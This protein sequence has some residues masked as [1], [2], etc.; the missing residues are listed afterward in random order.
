MIELEIDDSRIARLSLNRPDVHNAFNAEL[1]AELARVFGEIAEAGDVR[2]LVLTG[3]G[4]S[5]SAGA[6][7]N[8]MRGMARAGEAENR[9]DAAGLA[10][11]LRKLDELPCPTVARVNGAAMGGGGGLVAC[12][13]I[14]VAGANAR[15]A[16]SEVRLGLIPATIAPFVLARIGAGQAR[17]WMLTAERFDALKAREIGLVHEVT[18]PD[19]LDEMIDRITGA[20]VETGPVA[21]SECKKLIRALSATSFS[22]MEA[23]RLTADWIARLRV[24]PEGQE[25]LTAFLEKRKPDWGH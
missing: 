2:A 3:S 19:Q 10:A 18:E 4:K 23:D 1:I 11:M 17:R 25:G 12:C 15:F 5:F 8:W 22:A 13:D 9:A 24:S 6:D 7:M 21:S 20:V 14:A 16:L